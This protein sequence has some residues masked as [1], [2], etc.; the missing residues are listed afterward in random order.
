MGLG[1]LATIAVKK[2]AN[3]SIVVLDNGHYGETGMQRTHTAA[4]VDIAGMATAAGFVQTC[5]VLDE[6]ALAEFTDASRSVAGPLLGV[7]KVAT[8]KVP[9]VMPPR[10]G[11]L[12]KD[13]FREAVLGTPATN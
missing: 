9:L 6:S 8:D 3:L 2:P 7:I 13:R 1:G 5:T 4:G 12:L 10:D 11:A